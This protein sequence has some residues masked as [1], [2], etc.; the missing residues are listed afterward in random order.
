VL[1][2]SATKIANM[3]S[4]FGLAKRMHIDDTYSEKDWSIRCELILL[5]ALVLGADI[6]GVGRVSIVHHGHVVAL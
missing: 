1:Q 2:A 6:S 3:A 5:A 4:L